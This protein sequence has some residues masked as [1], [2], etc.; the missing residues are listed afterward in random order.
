MFPRLADPLV[1]L[2]QVSLGGGP[3]LAED[4]HLEQEQR[5]DVGV[6]R[7][8]AEKAVDPLRGAGVVLQP[9]VRTRQAELRQDLLLLVAQVAPGRQ[10]QRPAVFVLPGEVIAFPQH[11]H[12]AGDLGLGLA[13][14][15][16][17]RPAR[18]ALARR[19]SGRG[20]QWSSAWRNS[21]RAGLAL[22]AVG[23]PPGVSW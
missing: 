18:A 12:L 8:P 23:P 2:D 5:A 1:E 21:R 15:V 14:D 17:P 6:V 10:E 20:A 16:G 13:A 22:A 11:E 3:L 9:E 19:R 4:Q 7:V